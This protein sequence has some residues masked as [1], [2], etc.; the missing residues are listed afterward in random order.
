[1]QAVREKQRITVCYRSFSNPDGAERLIAPH[2][3]VSAAGRWHV[4]AF[5]E[6]DQEFKD[7]MLHRFVSIPEIDSDRLELANPERD[8]EWFKTVEMVL[9]PN[10][11]LDPE[12]QQLVADDYAM[13][14]DQQLPVSVRAPLVKYMVVELRI[15]TP[16]QA[17]DNP[18]AHQLVLA[19]RDELGGLIL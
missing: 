3:L 18:N 8:K 5:C 1:M 13:G 7:F 2:T 12:Q 19:N 15:G 6:K 17:A 14:P 16:E 9:I 11:A 4:R 10:P